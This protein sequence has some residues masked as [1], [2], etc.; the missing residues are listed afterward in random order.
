MKS[1]VKVLVSIVA[2]AI[3]PIA[4]SA[5]QVTLLNSGTSGATS[6]TVYIGYNSN[7]AFTGAAPTSAGGSG[8]S[9]YT[10]DL[11]NTTYSTTTLNGT[12]GA[13]V[14]SALGTTSP[15][16][17]G[18]IGTSV[19][20]SFEGTTG[21]NDYTQPANA[22]TVGVFEYMSDAFAST[23]QSLQLSV[24][25]DNTTAIWVVNGNNQAYNLANYPGCYTAGT[26]DCSTPDYSTVDTIT[27]PNADLTATGNVLYF[28]V[29]NTDNPVNGN[30]GSPTGLDYELNS[31]SPEPSSLL[32]LVTGMVGAAG[33]VRRRICA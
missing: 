31:V 23:G 22:N 33:A 13:V 15:Q 2:V 19:W 6:T 9:S 1:V 3:C 17:A 5:S 25:A 10:A 20:V 11:P 27:I 32:L 30:T 29:S 21:P 7:P 18:P 12:T 24:L 4:A 26:A 8:W 14:S 28:D 16:W